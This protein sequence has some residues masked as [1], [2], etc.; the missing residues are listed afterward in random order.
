MSNPPTAS[1]RESE[2]A[3]VG[4]MLAP[5]S[6]E[7][8]PTEPL[9]RSS[10]RGAVP[11]PGMVEIRQDDLEHLLDWHNKSCG[12]AEDEGMFA[13]LLAALPERAHEQ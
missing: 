5:L 13:R 6:D 8:Q 10:L 2:W 3:S 7:P 12:D 4:E 11:A 1:D 9:R